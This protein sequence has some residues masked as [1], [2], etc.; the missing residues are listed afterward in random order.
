MT[1]TTHTEDAL[2]SPLFAMLRAKQERGSSSAPRGNVVY[3]DREMDS[4]RPIAPHLIF[5]NELFSAYPALITDKDFDFRMQLGYLSQF[6]ISQAELTDALRTGLIT[7]LSD[8]GDEIHFPLEDL[9]RT[10]LI[11]DCITIRELAASILPSEQVAIRLRRSGVSIRETRQI[12]EQA[13]LCRDML[14]HTAVSIIEAIQKSGE[15]L[16]SPIEL[17]ALVPLNERLELAQ[18]V[19]SNLTH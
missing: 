15:E 13:E 1:H 10:Q 8:Q 16:L 17:E 7:I 3:F 6:S 19:R 11:T 4:R 12:L 18:Q 9:D 5:A 2:I 14:K